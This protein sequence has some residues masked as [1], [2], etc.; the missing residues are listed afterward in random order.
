MAPPTPCFLN[1]SSHKAD[2]HHRA[3]LPLPINGES[4]PLKNTPPQLKNEVPFQEVITRKK[5][6]Y[7]ELP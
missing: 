7:W 5:S 4:P 1:A 3:T 6:K 2:A